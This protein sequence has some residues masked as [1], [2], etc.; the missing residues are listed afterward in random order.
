MAALVVALDARDPALQYVGVQSLKT[1]TGLEYGGDVAKWRQ[2]AT[3]G[4]PTPSAP[5][6]PSIAERI[7]DAA[8]F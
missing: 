1:I 3:G 7:R 4:T 5:K 2:V 6:P 8:P